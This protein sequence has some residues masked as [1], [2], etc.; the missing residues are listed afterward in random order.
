VVLITPDYHHAS[1]QTGDHHPP[2]FALFLSYHKDA[3]LEAEE[4][5]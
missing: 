1:S 3:S 5:Q 4:E 2:A